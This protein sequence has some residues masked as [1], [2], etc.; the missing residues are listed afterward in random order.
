MNRVATALLACLFVSVGFAQ[1]DK[2][3]S[4]DY[5]GI[6]R[7]PGYYIYGYTDQQFNA[8]AF[9]VT[10]NGKTTDQQVEGRMIKLNYNIKDG[11]P[12]TSALQVVRNYH[13]AMR[14]AGG[15]VLNEH[16]DGNWSDSTLRFT[17]DGKEVWIL[18]E[19]RDDAH[20]LT[21][22]E[23]QAMQQD[24]TVDA[25]AMAQGLSATGSVAIYGIHFDTAKAELKPDSEPALAEIAK[26]LK[27]SATLRV[28]IVGHTDMVGDVGVNLKLSQERAQ[29]VIAALVSKY[30]I[31]ASR[32]TAFGNGSYAPVASN[33]TEEGR[34]K[35]R[36]V[37]LV[38]VTTK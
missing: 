29:S 31:A 27:S 33:K 35:N 32:L 12:P 22:V 20:V 8:A 15:Q 28:F 3:G 38:E 17:K 9:P 16:K 4:K 14:A 24:V 37:E 5:P 18:L 6:T 19:V 25:A 13:N 30:G 10:A 36:R 21:I 26:L 34:A 2:E 23:R 11:V 7:M 1:T